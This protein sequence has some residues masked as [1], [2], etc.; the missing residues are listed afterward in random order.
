[1]QVEKD[2]VVAFHYKLTLDSG[3]IVDSSEDREPLNFLVGHGQIIPGLEKELIGMKVGE[4]K[5]VQVDSKDGYG[6]R[7]EEL[8]QIVDRDQIPENIELKEGLVLRANKD[9]G[10]IV[11]FT[12][13]SFDE[14]KVVFDLNHPLAG[15][16]LNFDTEIINI[17]NAT[18]EEISHGHVH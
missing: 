17:R 11:E 5:S 7:D 15:E 4:K 1:M 14:E 6:E 9:D 18:E 2:K 10:E 13:Q 8:L 12:V 3:E 16:T